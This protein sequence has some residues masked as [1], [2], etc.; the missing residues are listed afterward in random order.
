MQDLGIDFENFE[1]EDYSEDDE[2]MQIV[3]KVRSVTGAGMYDLTSAEEGTPPPVPPAVD[4]NELDP[5]Q[6][7]VVLGSQRAMNGQTKVAVITASWG[8]YQGRS[9]LTAK[10]EISKADAN[11]WRAMQMD[12]SDTKAEAIGL[13][14]GALYDVRVS[15]LKPAGTPSPYSLVENVL[16]IADPVR[17]ATPTS[18]QTTVSGSVVTVSARAGNDN[19]AYLLFKRGTTSQTFDQATDISG[20]V[21]VSANQVIYID[22]TPGPGTWRY[23]ARA[24]NGSGIINQ[25]NAGPASRTVT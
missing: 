2:N 14:D 1:I 10:A 4:Y 24:K 5:P 3:M 17:P 22:D 25:T 21:R 19:T 16:A 15:W 11:V 18:L 12:N 9:D 7:L 13:E 6:N 8:A 23:W 20:E